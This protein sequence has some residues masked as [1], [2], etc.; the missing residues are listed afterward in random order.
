[1]KNL[2]IGL[3]MATLLLVVTGCSKDP[4]GSSSFKMSV[5]NSAVA[6]PSAGNSAPAVPVT[7]TDGTYTYTVTEARIN[8]RD[9]GFDPSA[10]V[11][12]SADKVEIAGPFV[13]DLYNNTASP[14]LPSFDL[15]A[16]NY[17]R[18]DIRFDD[19]D[20]ADGVLAAG[21][22]LL[23]NSMIV[24]GTYTNGGAVNSTFSILLKF[25]ED[26]RL[27]PVGGIVVDTGASVDV[28]MN[29]RVTDWLKDSYGNAI[30]LTGCIAGYTAGD[31]VALTDDGST[32][33]NDSNGDPVDLE[34]VIKGNLKNKYDFSS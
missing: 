22:E 21:D 27:E 6:K 12:S 17:Q 2:L 16:G 25:N 23:N 9:F 1:M 8:V 13:F 18:L 29:L 19:A 33:C 11:S 30:S 26:L 3:A 14:S 4:A 34:S 24:K 31:V 15:P 20:A 5:A 28:L 7:F 10:D 32:S